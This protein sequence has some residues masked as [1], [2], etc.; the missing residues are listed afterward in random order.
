MN[1]NKNLKRVIR[2]YQRARDTKEITIRQHIIQKPTYKLHK[3]RSVIM[4]TFLQRASLHFY[5]RFLLSS[6]HDRI[7]LG[8]HPVM[9]G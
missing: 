1:N 6:T 7:L 8:K 4:H 2:T 9:G 3:Y 5:A